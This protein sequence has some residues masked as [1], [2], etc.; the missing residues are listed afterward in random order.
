MNPEIQILQNKW[1]SGL[2]GDLERTTAVHLVQCLLVVGKREDVGDHA[3]GADLAA[4]E[5]CNGAREAVRLGEGTN[6]LDI[7]R[8]VVN[9]RSY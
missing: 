2:D 4:I 8:N 3:L 1:C 7:A 6:D 9:T 5:V